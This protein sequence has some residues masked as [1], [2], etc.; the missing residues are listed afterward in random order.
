MEQKTTLIT[1]A[2]NGIGKHLLQQLSQHNHKLIILGRNED[3]LAN[4]VSELNQER[5]ETEVWTYQADMADLNQVREVARQIAYDHHH[6]DILIN[7][8]GAIHLSY[9]ATEEGLEKTFVVNYFSHFTLT[10]ILLPLLKAAPQ[11]LVINVSSDCYKLPAYG[12]DNIEIS[13]AYN[14]NK[15]YNRSKLA[16]VQFTQSLAQKL[17]AND[18]TVICI[19]PGGVRTDI[20]KP[21]PRVLR[22]FIGLTLKPIHKGAQTILDAALHDS[23]QCFHGQFLSGGKVRNVKKKFVSN[24]QLNSLW[25]YSMSCTGLMAADT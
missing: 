9:E 19:S 1:G 24:S 25:Q 11:G 15:A 4:A 18:V 22:W 6:I 7:N 8:A 2:T 3:K 17:D 10:H 14:F 23:P 5:P 21:L 13:E 16:Q 20:Y 12:T